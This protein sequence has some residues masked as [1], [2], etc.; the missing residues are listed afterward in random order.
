[1]AIFMA[2]AR[3]KWLGWSRLDWLTWKVSSA[4]YHTPMHERAWIR[5]I[6]ILSRHI[7]RVPKMAILWLKSDHNGSRLDWPTW[8]AS[9]APYH[10]PMHERAWIRTIFTLSRALRFQKEALF[11]LKQTKIAVLLQFLSTHIG[12]YFSSYCLVT[13]FPEELFNQ[14]L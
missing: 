4:P 14:T 7:S 12:K 13:Y 10:T 2:E 1:M 11:G 6:I 8:K 9:S 3:P 5:T